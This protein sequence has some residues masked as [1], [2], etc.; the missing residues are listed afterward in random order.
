VYQENRV[1]H[2]V[3]GSVLVRMR[4]NS[5]RALTPSKSTPR[6]WRP[7]CTV[8]IFAALVCA[9][10]WPA[11]KTGR[12]LAMQPVVSNS[13][14][15]G[16]WLDQ[17]PS[18]F[19][20]SAAEIEPSPACKV[21]ES[22]LALLT[23]SA[24][25][26]GSIAQMQLERCRGDLLGPIDRCVRAG[27]RVQ[28]TVMAFPFKVPNPAKAG[29][30]QMPDLAE[31][32]ALARLSRLNAKAK[33]LYPPGLEIHIIHDGSY[34]ADIFGIPL[35]EVRAYERY[36]ARLVHAAGADS[37][38]YQ[39]DFQDLLQACPRSPTRQASQFRDTLLDWPRGSWRSPEWAG[40]FSKTLGMINLRNLPVDELCRLMDHASCGHLPPEYHDLE[41]FV[42]A[43]MLR[44]YARDSL[45]HA[46]DP[47]SLCFPDAIHATTLCRPRRLAIWL[48]NRGNSLLPWHGVGL[49]D[50]CGK[51]K[52]VLAR[53]VL[54]NPSYAPVVLEGEDTP[55]FYRECG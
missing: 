21:A 41:R 13:V 39:H 42:H 23:S 19:S 54:Q 38:L 45:L 15:L 22:L 43:A 16:S 31:L 28:L 55:F 12:A 14:S 33:S 29:P 7:V 37:F 8:S 5:A 26:K 30:R 40:Q 53:T 44:Y 6:K 32:A 20:D 24:V 27:R 51:W 49:I 10:K 4:S 52:V 35:Q 34:I 46:C 48:V 9:G 18:P 36:F 25:R 11:V 17:V 50:R 1:A 3:T 2:Y 47:R